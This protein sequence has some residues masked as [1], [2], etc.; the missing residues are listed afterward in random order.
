MAV[1]FC[2]T[3]PD[4]NK[5]FSSTLLMLFCS[6]VLSEAAVPLQPTKSMGIQTSTYTTWRRPMPEQEDAWEEP[7]MLWEA[8]GERSPH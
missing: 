2:S 7:V 8:G 1:L 3:V 6:T 5:M 4:K